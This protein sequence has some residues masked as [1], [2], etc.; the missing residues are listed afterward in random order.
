MISERLFNG[1]FPERR[2]TVSNILAAGEE[3]VVKS[4]S[5]LK[6]DIQVPFSKGE[7]KSP[8]LVLNRSRPVFDQSLETDAQID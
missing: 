5:T 6:G 3:W 2:R 4:L 7:Y 8:D 1:D